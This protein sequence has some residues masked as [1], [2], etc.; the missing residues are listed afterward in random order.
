VWAY[1]GTMASAKHD[2][3]LQVVMEMERKLL[4]YI[5]IILALLLLPVGVYAAENYR[6]TSPSNSLDDL[7]GEDGVFIVL[8][9]EEGIIIVYAPS[10]STTDVPAKG[11]VIANVNTLRKN[12][13]GD[14]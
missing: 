6:T 10:E 8:E 1:T 11:N 9:T 13:S 3:G 12:F 7:E 14:A 4:P 2:F 5:V